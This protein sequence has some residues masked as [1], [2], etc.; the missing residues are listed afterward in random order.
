MEGSY[1]LRWLGEQISRLTTFARND[2]SKKENNYY[3]DFEQLEKL[4]KENEINDINDILND[5]I[6]S[7]NVCPFEVNSIFANVDIDT[8]EDLEYAEYLFQKTN[9]S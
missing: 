8:P 7:E 6:I 1:H 2:K 3:P 5:K 9:I 4:I